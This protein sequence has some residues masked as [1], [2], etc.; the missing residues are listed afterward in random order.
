MNITSWDI[1]WITRLD[2]IRDSIT[3]IVVVLCVAF[4]IGFLSIIYAG[5]ESIVTEQTAWRW[6]KRVC[7]GFTIPAALL[8]IMPFIPT[9]KEACMVYAIPKLADSEYTK[10]L[11]G[12]A[13]ELYT[14]AVEKMKGELKNERKS[15]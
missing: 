15:K 12:D 14:L 1:Y 8:L 6:M 13:K 10:T 9:T 4:I 3:G 7:W 5:G 2:S 11:Q